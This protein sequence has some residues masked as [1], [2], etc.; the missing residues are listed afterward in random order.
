MF[1]LLCFFLARAAACFSSS[2]QLQWMHVCA[3]AS[4][5]L[6]Y[7]W[8]LTSAYS[9][10]QTLS[11]LWSSGVALVVH[12]C[13]KHGFHIVVVVRLSM[14]V[15]PAGLLIAVLVIEIRM[16]RLR[17]SVVSVEIKECLSCWL[18]ASVRNCLDLINPTCFRRSHILFFPFERFKICS[19]DFRKVF[20]LL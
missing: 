14:V 1:L 17:Q 10:S 7:F 11:L 8:T 18:T 6:S 3:R 13:C 4:V 2:M 12:M 5:I 9:C 20:M 19:H 16:H 15:F